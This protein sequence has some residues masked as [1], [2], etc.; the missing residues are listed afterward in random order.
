VTRTIRTLV[1]ELDDPYGDQP[2]E[3][4]PG[5]WICRRCAAEIYHR[6]SLCRHCKRA[7]TLRRNLEYPEES[8]DE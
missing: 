3:E 1:D 4:S 7:D 6:D 5:I 8:D 2:Y